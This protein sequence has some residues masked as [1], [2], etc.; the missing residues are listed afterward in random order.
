MIEPMLRE[1]ASRLK[2]FGAELLPESILIRHGS[3]EGR[4]LALTFDDGPD[5]MTPTYLELLETLGVEATFFVTGANC[6]K[7]PQLVRDIEERGHE[8]AG[9]GYTHTRFTELD[10]SAL[11]SE[12]RQTQALLPKPA[13]RRPLVRP[14]HGALSPRALATIAYA[15]FTTAMWSHNSEDWRERDPALLAQHCEPRRLRAG[16][17]MLLHEGQQWTLDALPAIT[18]QLRSAGFELTT[19]S[20]L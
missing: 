1:L 20:G 6:A 9:H 4:R 19:V 10:T 15:G 13:G 16:D 14:P 2:T 7:H 12:L 18:K 11:L 17:I 3:R 5:E 8:L